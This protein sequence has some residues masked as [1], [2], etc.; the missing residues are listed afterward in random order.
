VAAVRDPAYSAGV[1]LVAYGNAPS[2]DSGLHADFFADAIAGL[3]GSLKGI[4]SSKGLIQ[5]NNKKEGGML[6]LKS[7]K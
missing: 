1:G 2:T 7:K 5:I 4:F 6:C 3:K